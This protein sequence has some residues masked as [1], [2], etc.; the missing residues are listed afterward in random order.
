MIRPSRMNTIAKLPEL[1]ILKLLS[2]SDIFYPVPGSAANIL[3]FFFTLCG[4]NSKGFKMGF[5][6]LVDKC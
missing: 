5:M 4:N 1:L 2:L 3:Q 6:A